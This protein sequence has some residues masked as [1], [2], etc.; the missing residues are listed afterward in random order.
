[1]K[2]N[3]HE[4]FHGFLCSCGRYFFRFCLS[5]LTLLAI[6]VLLPRKWSND[7]KS[8]CNLDVCVA[9]SGV[10]TDI[11]VPTKNHVVNW[12]QYISIAD[13]GI[14]KNHDYSY[15]SFGWGD[16]D[17]Y[18]STPSVA[19]IKLSTTIKALFLPT[20]SVMYVKGYN[21]IPDYWDVKCIKINEI[22]YLQ[23][24]KFIQAS[25]QLDTK[26]KNIRL[27]DG[28]T[29]NGGFYAA[30]GSYSILRNC[31]SW[32]AEGLRKADINTPLGDSIPSA[33]LWH[34]RSNCKQ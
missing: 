31:N 25:F 28:H 13:I 26:G 27:G 6:A 11:I 7:L 32:T 21:L 16:R 24:M 3:N 2:V 14:D 15:L 20:P 22:D 1:M 9:S 23:L 30:N 34:L 18:M 17:F 10:H 4:F 19:D 5:S 29:N 8:N 12:H 33:I